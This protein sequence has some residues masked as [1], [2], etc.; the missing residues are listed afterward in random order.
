MAHQ[1]MPVTAFPVVQP[2][3]A[4]LVGAL[5]RLSPAPMVLPRLQRLLADPNAGLFQVVELVRL[6]SALTARVVQ[7][8]NSAWFGRGSG[9]GTIE[10]AVNRVGFHEVHRL[11]ATAAASAVVVQSL[12]AYGLDDKAMWRESVACA[13]AAE[14]L[15]ARVGEDTAEAYTIGLLHAVGRVA[16]NNHA[17]GAGRTAR[18]ADA[19]FPLEQS[20]DEYSWLGFTQAD[21]GACMLQN[22]EFGP[23]MVEP[24]R[25]QYQP[26]QA[27]APHDRMAA[28]VYGA[29]LLRTIVCQGGAENPVRAD[30]AVLAKLR[31]SETELLGMLPDLHEQLAK[32]K[33]MTDLR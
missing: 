32:A 11:V 4:R 5:R 3:P 22:W 12:S 28:V 10:E 29:R 31:L 23:T 2:T 21:A 7:V 14:M 30:S 18:L 6:D 20:A 15:A 16:I 26:L 9:C 27:L 25:A 33:Q 13:F 8:S 17:L 19:S 24:V 1:I